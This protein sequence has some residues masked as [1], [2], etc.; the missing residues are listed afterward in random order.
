MA[1]QQDHKREDIA[2]AVKATGGHCQGDEDDRPEDIAR[3]MKATDRRTLPG[4]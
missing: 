3:V 2:R 4:Q 1:T